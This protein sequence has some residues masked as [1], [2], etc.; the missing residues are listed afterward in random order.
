MKNIL[1]KIIYGSE[2]TINRMPS[3]NNPFQIIRESYLDKYNIKICKV[4]IDLIEALIEMNIIE[5]YSGNF[6]TQERHYLLND[7]F[8]SFENNTRIIKLG[9]IWKAILLNNTKYISLPENRIQKKI[10]N[11]FSELKNQLLRKEK[12]KMLNERVKEN[13]L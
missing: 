2:V 12:L 13:N 3:T 7:K 6:D 1:K 9:E 5:C 8:I 10:Q 4:D 11:A